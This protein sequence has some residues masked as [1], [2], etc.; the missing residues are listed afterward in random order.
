MDSLTL[1]F[2]LWT[3]VSKKDVGCI[4]RGLIPWK[5]VLNYQDFSQP[6]E[7]VTES[8]EIVGYLG[9]M[10]DV[11]EATEPATTIFDQSPERY[12]E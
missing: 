3:T 4:G 11:V 10:V 1:E 6:L 5:E 12:T 7:M 8:G 2:Q 9:I